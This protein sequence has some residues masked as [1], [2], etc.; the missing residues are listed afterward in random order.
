MKKIIRVSTVPSS[1]EVFLKGFLKTLSTE[2]NVIAISSP[3]E[4][5]EIVRE[6][7]GV[8]TVAIRMERHISIFKDFVSLFRLIIVFIKEKPDMVHSM[9]PK[10]GLLSMLAAWITSVPVRMHT[11]TGLIFPTHTGIKRKV[12]K[13]MDRLICSCATFINPEGQGVA[14]DLIKNNITKKNLN[15]IANGNVRGVDMTWYDRTNEVLEKAEK[16]RDKTYFT[17]CFVGRLVRDKGVNELVKAFDRLSKLKPNIRLLLVGGEE[18]SLDPLSIETI[19]ILTN[20]NRIINFG[21]QFDVRPFL[22]ASDAFV[23]PSYREGFPNV[24]LEAGALGLPAIVT[25]I[26]GCNEIIISRENGE[27]IPPR[28]EDAL[29]NKMKDWVEQPEQ[30]STMASKT[31]YLIENR[32]EQTKIWNELLRIYREL[33]GK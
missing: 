3:G 1:L 22:T 7:E 18:T 14:S 9:T 2:Y 4:K 15:I 8:R 6:R 31:R 17:F 30:I 5:L 29:Y 21:F 33:L 28:D 32:Y 23:F 26:N 10:A 12:L 13:L 27:M 11:F 16:I 25:D 24:V 19:K 20:N